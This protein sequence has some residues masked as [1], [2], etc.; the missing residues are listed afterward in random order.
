[1][2]RSARERRAMFAN[3]NRRG[4]SLNAYT[5]EVP[6]WVTVNKAPEIRNEPVSLDGL[7]QLTQYANENI[8]PVK[9]VGATKIDDEYAVNGPVELVV[10]PNTKNLRKM[11][12]IFNNLSEDPDKMDVKLIGDK[13]RVVINGKAKLLSI[14]ENSH[15]V[16]FNLGWKT[17]N[18]L[19]DGFRLTEFD[20]TDSERMLLKDK[21][22]EE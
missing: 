16:K 10:K 11:D 9:R 18:K 13:L 20:L 3:M 15:I 7:D 21:F 2:N 1:M 17:K 22:Y 8:R 5:P 6:D 19:D 14:P 12:E 4:V